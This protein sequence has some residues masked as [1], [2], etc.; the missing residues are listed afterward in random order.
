MSCERGLRERKKAA[1]RAALAAAA[2]RLAIEHGADHVTV[3]A[4]AAEA[5]VSPR[6]F[7]N[8]F[9]SREEAM[10]A[11]VVDFGWNLTDRLQERPADEPIWDAL[12][13]VIVGSVDASPQARERIA[14]QFEMFAGNPAVLASQLAALDGMRIRFASVV[15]ARTGTD[16]GY[17]M[18]PH[19]VAS[20]AANALKTAYDLWATRRDV[21]LIDLVDQAFAMIRAG[22]PEPGRSEPC[23]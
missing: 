17:D 23:S 19:L 7:H 1:T 21:G 4:I 18:Y 3:E 11:S 20:A 10:V 13:D 6:T 22:L 8:Y 5:D 15:A 12:R 14:A 2:S 9:S 16:A